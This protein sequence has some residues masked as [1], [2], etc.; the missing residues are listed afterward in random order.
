MFSACIYDLW[1]RS[2]GNKHKSLF[3]LRWVCRLWS[4]GG[5]LVNNPVSSFSLQTLCQ[6][7][8]WLT[9]RAAS[10]LSLFLKW[11]ISS[12]QVLKLTHCWFIFKK[13][14]LSSVLIPGSVSWTS[15][16]KMPETQTLFPFSHHSD[17]AQI[18]FYVRHQLHF[19]FV[20]GG[21]TVHHVFSF[22]ILCSS[23]TFFQRHHHELQKQVYAAVF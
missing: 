12:N 15:Q 8:S 9:H 20:H 6:V 5:G 23:C 14:D 17:S 4:G 19:H 10:L 1:Q 22:S 3:V 16:T 18:L 13:P 11:F 2:R 7:G 21:I